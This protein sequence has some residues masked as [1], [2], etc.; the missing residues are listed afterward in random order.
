MLRRVTTMAPTQM[1]SPPQ[2]LRLRRSPDENAGR[3]FVA[4][5]LGLVLRFTEPHGIGV[6]L[7]ELAHPGPGAEGVPGH[8]VRS[9]ER[10]GCEREQ[11]S[12]EEEQ[13]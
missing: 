5:I 9:T 3:P 8:R 6:L 4:L 13:P 7:H 1:I 10:H 12:P 2:G 11:A